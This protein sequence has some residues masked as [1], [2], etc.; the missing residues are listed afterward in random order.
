MSLTTPL[1]FGILIAGLGLAAIAHA[2]QATVRAEAETRTVDCGG[3]D[4]EVGGNRNTLTFHGGCRDF[5][6]RGDA[7]TVTI[8]LA[9]GARVDIE[10]NRNHIRYSV[11][12]G[13]APPTVRV[14][15][16]DTDLGPAGSGPP[17]A[18]APLPVRLSGDNQR[19]DVDCTGG[20]VDIQGNRSAYTLRGGCRSLVAHGDGNTLRAE[21]QPGARVEVEG[22]GTTL[23]YSLRGS[24]AEPQVVVRGND[25][26]VTRASGA[27]PGLPASPPAPAAPPAPATPPSPAPQPGPTGVPL[28][29]PA[30]AAPAAFPVPP[31]V[32][33]PTTS[34]PTPASFAPVTQPPPTVRSVPQLMRDLGGKVV[35]QGTEVVFPAASMFD[36]G[37]DTLRG[38][39]KCTSH[40]SGEPCCADPPERLAHHRFGPVKPGACG[41]ARAGGAGLAWHRRTASAGERER[42]HRRRRRSHRADREVGPPSLSEAGRQNS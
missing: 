22:N 14:S 11:V 25:S 20:D 33:P 35:E 6:L 23:T 10:G 16:S 34:A 24:G 12:G 4:A 19:L 15:G 21:L 9:P 18:P 30:P 38:D 40:G 42:R 7:N 17:P 13:G 27:V 36:D 26:H 3:G 29:T 5:L 1:S 28:P 32:P 41:A 31:P 8:E 2:Q 39:A 37:S